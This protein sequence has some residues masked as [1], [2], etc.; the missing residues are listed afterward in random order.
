MEGKWATGFMFSEAEAPRATG[1]SKAAPR[2]A[3]VWPLVGGSER[4]RHE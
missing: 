2:K 4:G 3:L 1:A